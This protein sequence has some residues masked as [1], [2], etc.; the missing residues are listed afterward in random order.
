MR[1]LTL[2][3]VYVPLGYT[4]PYNSQL[5]EVAG[6]SPWGVST[7]AAGDGSRQP[8]SGELALAEHQG[9]VSL[10]IVQQCCLPRSVCALHVSQLPCPYPLTLFL[11][12]CRVCRHLCSRQAGVSCAL[13]STFDRIDGG[14]FSIRDS[15][16]WRKK[17][18]DGN[19]E[20]ER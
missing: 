7:V 17:H 20:E 19:G 13:F 8:T 3:V 16:R 6:G 12:L 1:P 2:T 15:E 4:S 14:R 10:G 9:K 11:D 18:G 5:D